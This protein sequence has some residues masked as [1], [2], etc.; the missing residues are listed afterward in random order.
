MVLRTLD[1]DVSLVVS[2][3]AVL[4]HIMR[5]SCYIY[6]VPSKAFLTR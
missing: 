4:A 1:G 3:D 6:I 2:A 5:L